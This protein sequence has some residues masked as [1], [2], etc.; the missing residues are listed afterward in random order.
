M[1]DMNIASQP[2]SQASPAEKPKV[3]NIDLGDTPDEVKAQKMQETVDKLI[4][5]EFMPW[6]MW[7]K[8]FETLWDEIYK[9]YF[10]TVQ[11]TKTPTRARIFIPIVFQTIEATVPKVLNTLF[12]GEE[13]FDVVPVMKADE[14]MADSIKLLLLY[15]LSQADIFLKFIDFSK[16][17]FLYGTS[18]LY[19]Y[20]KVRRQWVYTKNVTRG[21]KSF[22]GW[23]LG[24]NTVQDVQENKDYK[25]VEKRPEVDVL[26]ILDVYPD[27]NAKSDRPGENGKAIWVRT[28][29]DLEDL[30][31]L[32]SG[33]FPQYDNVQDERLDGNTDAMIMDLRANRVAARNLTQTPSKNRIEVLSRWGLFD[34]D[35]DGIREETLI[36]I[37]NRKVM[38]K[39]K[40]N[41]FYHQKRPILRSVCFPVINEWYGIGLIEPIIPLQHEINTLRRQR[42]DNINI[43]INRMWLVSDMADVDIDTLISAPNGV[44]LTKDMNGVKPL[45][46]ADVTQSNYLEVQNAQNDIENATITKAAQGTPESGRLGRTA[47]GAKL[48]VGAALEKFGVIV[49]LIEDSALKRTLRMFHQLNIQMINDDDTLRDPGMYGHLFDEKID[50]DMLKAEVSFKMV[51]VSEMIGKESKIN[52]IISYMGVFGNFLDGQ[53][54]TAL[55]KKVWE[56]MGFDPD[57]IELQ[58]MANPQGNPPPPAGVDQ[59]TGAAVT[60]QTMRN[61]SGAPPTIP[62][63]NQGAQ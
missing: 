24:K 8:P 5:E 21:T 19:V 52:Q 29:M 37:A 10:S 32:G 58:G 59:Q 57:Q 47:S 49:R 22:F 12:N 26:D 46:T 2:T 33:P 35:G 14:P 60:G 43:V 55:S 15:Q 3:V 4:N 1:D 62:G 50:A 41:P 61:G 18:Y 9:L 20:W 48:I 16:Q 40:A 25:V 30:K 54:I 45:D 44:V 17:L 31:E 7:R 51:G 11:A 63:T 56:L 42:L 13:F 53:S 28:M 6:S 34:L 39:A 23:V 27:P 38:I 36:V